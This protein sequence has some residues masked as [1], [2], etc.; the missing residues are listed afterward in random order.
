MEGRLGQFDLTKAC[1]QDNFDSYIYFNTYIWEY[2]LYFF[3]VEDQIIMQVML[4]PA[5][6]IGNVIHIF[7]YCWIV[8]LEFH[9][10]ES[11]PFKSSL[12][13][14]FLIQWFPWSSVF[15]RWHNGHVWLQIFLDF[16]VCKFL[17]LMI[18]VFLLW[19]HRRSHLMQILTFTDFDKIVYINDQRMILGSLMLELCRVYATNPVELRMCNF[20]N[21]FTLKS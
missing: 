10:L 15:S 2:M 17:I 11:Y 7:F 5:K 14:V 21:L 18:W 1:G 3:D 4:S 12:C 19:D 16:T 9:T 8:V 13:N 6:L 20:E